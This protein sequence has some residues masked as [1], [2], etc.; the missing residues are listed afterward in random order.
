MT[1]PADF[2]PHPVFSLRKKLP[3]DAEG[4]ADPGTQGKPRGAQSR[5]TRSHKD[6][7]EYMRERSHDCAMDSPASGPAQLLSGSFWNFPP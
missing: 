1:L 3:E 5:R 6:R 4:K 2:S 7:G